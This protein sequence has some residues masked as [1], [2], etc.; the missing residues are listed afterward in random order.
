MFVHWPSVIAGSDSMTFANANAQKDP[1]VAVAGGEGVAGGEEVV[2]AVTIDQTT[3]RGIM[4]GAAEE[5]SVCFQ[6]FPRTKILIVFFAPASTI[7]LSCAF[8]LASGT[9]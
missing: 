9:W 7:S 2:S 4:A 1:S 5:A 8:S 3:E 6:S